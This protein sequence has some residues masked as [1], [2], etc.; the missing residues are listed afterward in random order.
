MSTTTAAAPPVA[1]PPVPRVET[2]FRRFVSEF[3]ESRLALCGLVILFSQ[4][5]VDQ[6]RL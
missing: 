6:F 5:Q 1:V 4:K 2:P 3:V